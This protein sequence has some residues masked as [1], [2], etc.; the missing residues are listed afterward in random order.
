MKGNGVKVAVVLFN[1]G[2]PDGPAAVRPFLANLFRDPAIIDLPAV[3]RIPL[4]KLI[5]RRREKAA[6]ANY[7][8]MGGASP[9]LPETQAQ[10]DALEAR[11][12]ARRPDVEA[13][14]FIA[15][16]YW[17][18]FAAETARAVAAFAP[19]EIV[20]LPL[21]PQYSTT[22]TASSLKDWRAAY[23]GPGRSRAVCC[24]PTAGGLVEAHAQ[25]IRRTWERAG[26][27]KGLRLLF[28][29]HG[30]P[31]KVVDA[32]DPYQA[33][34]EA[35]AG[36][37]AARLPELSDWR[38][39]Y[40]SRVGPL[41]WLAPSTDEEVRR[42]GAEGRGVLVAPIAF[43]SEHVETLVELDHEYARTAHEVGCRPYLRAPTPTV[44]EPFIEDLAEAALGA[45]GRTD[46]TRPYGPWLCPVGLGKCGCHL[47]ERP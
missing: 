12:K 20:L 23:K 6:Q 43:V 25:A 16:R 41:K 18:P 2:G 11:L 10:A 40:Q 1:L 36:R 29:A 27:P 19:D 44:S 22:T 31:Q 28:S 46:R 24:Y 39:C 15:M 5:A 13:R 30:L 3:A 47:E 34:V 4:A 8:L 33:Q 38:V 42:A 9:L 37:I 26:A 45:L 21:Y 7:D 35:T 32:G 14:V 17:K